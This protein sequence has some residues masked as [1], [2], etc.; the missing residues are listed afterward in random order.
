VSVVIVE[1]KWLADHL[2]DKNLIIIDSRG[3][4][5]YAYAHIL[6]S[7]PLGIEKVVKMAR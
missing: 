4:I 3:F 7:I 2:D 6:N 5:S 1:H